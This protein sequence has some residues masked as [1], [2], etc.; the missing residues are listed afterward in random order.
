MHRPL[1]TT[2]WLATLLPLAASAADFEKTVAATSGGTLRIE[3]RAGS[4][5]VIGDADEEVR[6]DARAT[7]LGAGSLDLALTSDGVDVELS[8][9]TGG[10]LANVL[11]DP[12]VRVRVRVPEEYSVDIETGAGSIDLQRLQGTVKART[13]G[14]S[15]EIDEVEG[16]VDVRTSGGPVDADSIEGDLRIETSGGRI[17]VSEVSGRVEARTS[18]GGIQIH[19]VGGPVEA[20]T[21]G[22][23]IS[24]RFNEAPEGTLETSGGGIQVEFPEDE[25]VD[26]DAETSG[27]R[28]EVEAGA[29]VHGRL[30]PQRVVGEL[31]GGGLRLQL[32][33]SGGNIRIRLR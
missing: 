11:R 1:Q 6:V 2:A 21:S 26:L 23:S 16:E 17:R 7:G 9:G 12:R 4:V 27:G 13:S 14:G 10:W 8:G 15:I 32:R 22:G 25:G 5:E 30:E 29:A 19:D 20:R 18:G 33:T 3:L 31:N 28:V 24:V